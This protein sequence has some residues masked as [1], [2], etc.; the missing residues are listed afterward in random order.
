[1][2][3][4]PFLLTSKS[5]RLVVLSLGVEIQQTAFQSPHSSVC[6]SRFSKM[7]QNVSKG[8]LLC[9]IVMIT[10][11]ENRDIEIKLQPSK[12]SFDL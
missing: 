10:E 6:T 2:S 7:L 9:Q 12:L 11:E 1:M 3:C 8:F 5:G 4:F